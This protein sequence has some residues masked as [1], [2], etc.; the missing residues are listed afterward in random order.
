MNFVRA[1]RV[2]PDASSLNMPLLFISNSETL[3]SICW[4]ITLHRPNRKYAPLNR[5]SSWCVLLHVE[6]MK[7]PAYS[8]PISPSTSAV[9]KIPNGGLVLTASLTIAQELTV[10][11][12]IRSDT[13]RHAKMP[14]NSLLPCKLYESLGTH[15]CWVSVV[16]RVSPALLIMCFPYA[17]RLTPLWCSQPWI[18]PDEIG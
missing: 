5:W 1:P 15:W 17:E 9:M 2:L 7:K 8:L 16:L 4:Q 13:V 18:Y 11:A 14:S 6:S 3:K 12:N 10:A